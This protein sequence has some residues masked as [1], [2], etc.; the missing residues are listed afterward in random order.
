MPEHNALLNSTLISYY[1]QLI[2]LRSKQFFD[3]IFPICEHVHLIEHEHNCLLIS[4]DVSNPNTTLVTIM[5]RF[6]TLDRQILEVFPKLCVLLILNNDVYLCETY[7]N[8]LLDYKSGKAML[9]EIIEKLD[10][11]VHELQYVS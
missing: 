5:Y 4:S 3:C 10:V 9:I 8:K 6:E 1:T 7:I 2:K 11:H